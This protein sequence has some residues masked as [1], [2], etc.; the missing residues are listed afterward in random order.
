MINIKEKI[1]NILQTTPKHVAANKRWLFLH[2]PI[3]YNFLKEKYSTFN[4]DSLS[5]TYYRIL[6]DIEEKPKCIVCGKPVHFQKNGIN[7]YRS[8]CSIYCLNNT[9]EGIKIKFDKAAKTNLEKYGSENPFGSPIIIEKLKR[10]W[11]EKY[12]VENPYAAEE[13]K[14]KIKQTLINRYGADHPQHSDIIKQKTAETNIKLYGNKM[15]LQSNI[16]LKRIYQ[17]RMHN[18]SKYTKYISKIEYSIIQYLEQNFPNDFEFQYKSELYPFNCDFYI[19]S[20]DLYIEVQGTWMHGGH[21]FDENN[22]EDINKLNFWKEKNTKQYI[23]ACDIWTIKDVE[24][25]NIAK[26]NNLNYL[27][28]FSIKLDE[29]IE[30]LNNYIKLLP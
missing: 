7:Q 15:Y 26:Q 9:P 21:P 8:F 13:V 4:E 1:Q 17:E 18:D 6:N 23:Y 5:E 30:Q 3:I 10:T 24:K 12:G 28:I 29:C 20:L 25:R 14:N 11:K 2:H 16:A 27:E 22:Q 19:K